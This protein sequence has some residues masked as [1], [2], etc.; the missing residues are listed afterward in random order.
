MTANVMIKTEVREGILRVPLRAVKSKNGDKIVEILV[1]NKET[2]ER[3]V[4]VGL[5]GDEFM[6]IANGLEAGEEVITFIKE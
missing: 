6:E 2:E 4:E 1:N 5:R 3:K